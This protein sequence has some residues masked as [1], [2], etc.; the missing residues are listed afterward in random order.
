M[1][2]NNS[3]Q[4]KVTTEQKQLDLCFTVIEQSMH[5]MILSF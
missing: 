4:Q 5:G 2:L 3:S 1:S